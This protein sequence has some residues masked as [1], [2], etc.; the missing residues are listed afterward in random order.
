MRLGRIFDLLEHIKES[1]P[2]NI[3]FSQKDQGD[4]K[5]CNGTEYYK[6]SY[7]L[8]YGLLASG[9]NP[10]DNVVT[11]L[12]NCMEWNFFDMAISLSACISIPL[13][14]KISDG[15]LE[16]IINLSEAK[17]IIIYDRHHAERLDKISENITKPIKI[18]SVKRLNNVYNWKELV[19][20]GKQ[21]S[22]KIGMQTK[23]IKKIIKRDTPFTI[24]FTSGEGNLKTTPIIFPWHPPSFSVPA[25]GTIMYS[26]TIYI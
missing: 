13:Y 20:L 16:Y 6:N 26:G 12:P 3:L 4:W 7:F 18:F 1:Y 10:G 15:F 21:N 9:L 14:D 25:Q 17:A 22:L 2:D 11:M 23:F 19:A 8:H 5:H 24:L